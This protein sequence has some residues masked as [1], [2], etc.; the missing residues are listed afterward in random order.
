MTE[1][2]REHPMYWNIN[3]TTAQD[4]VLCDMAEAILGR[5]RRPTV[6]LMSGTDAVVLENAKNDIIVVEEK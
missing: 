3:I 6:I 5:K 2:R 1:G 4:D